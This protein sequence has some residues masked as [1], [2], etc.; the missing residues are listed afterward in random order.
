MES[1]SL[2]RVLSAVEARGLS[3]EQLLAT[4]GIDPAWVEDR[5]AF[6]PLSQ[7]CRLYAAASAALGDPLFGLAVAGSAR[8][9]DYGLIGLI[10]QHSDTL[11]HAF[12][13]LAH[14]VHL[15]LPAIE[16][17]TTVSASEVTVRLT[18]HPELPG[19]E[20]LRQDL[21]AACF[22]QARAS[23]GPTR[24]FVPVRAAWRGVIADPARWTERFQVEVE[25]GASAEELVFRRADMES[26]LP[27]A[28]PQ[29]LAHLLDAVETQLTKRRA[30]AGRA[31]ARLR[32]SGC[33]VDLTEGIIERGDDTVHLTT[34]ERELLE[35]FVANRNRI[36]THEEIEQNI[37]HIGKTV[38]SHAPAVAIRR[39]RAKIEP[40]DG[41]P[42]NLITVFGEGW[43]LV[44]PEG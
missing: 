24:S 19:L 15:T 17:S 37:W 6:V 33:T 7:V 16:F 39:L 25:G 29:V 5:Q 40:P 14:I 18:Y 8:A 42:V 30:A 9:R 27:D 4:A 43:K 36:V 38:M 31:Q 20:L 22:E 21:F 1:V 13:E 35:Y 2:R 26:P 23:A 10:F 11:L 41:R 34:K 3:R 12:E 44:V 32:L 28:D